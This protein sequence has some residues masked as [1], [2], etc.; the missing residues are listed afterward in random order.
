MTRQGA[1]VE[2]KPGGGLFLK[3]T[4]RRHD[5]EERA[6]IERMKAGDRDAFDTIFRKHVKWVYRQA[7]R[8]MGNEADAEEVVQEIFLAVYE[9]ARA[10]RGESAFSTW[11]YR[12]TVNAAL[13]KL[14]RK[15]RSKEVSYEDFL[16]Q[17]QED[18]HHLVRP[19]I[20]WSDELEERHSKME[21]Q[22]FLQKALDQL[23]PQDK[24][25]V[26]LSD[27]EGISDREIGKILGLTVSAVKTRL[28]RARLFLRGRLAVLLGHSST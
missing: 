17:Y 1:S 8:L 24:A 20:D 28:H 6:L 13:S 9:K 23:R 19:V 18:G 5:R 21:L 3:R 22:Q 16:P 25:V 4:G 2:R 10:F 12:L 26:L 15:K 27:L 7:L 14:R 11:L